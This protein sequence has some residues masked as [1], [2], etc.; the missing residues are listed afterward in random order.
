MRVTFAHRCGDVRRYQ[1]GGTAADDDEVV[2]ELAGRVH[3]VD[4]ARFVVSALAASKSLEDH[5]R[6]TGLPRS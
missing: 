2:V 3:C 6:I 5:E 4:L 1:P